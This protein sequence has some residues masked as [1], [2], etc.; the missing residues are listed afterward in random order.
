MVF[1]FDIEGA[2]KNTVDWTKGAVSGGWITG[3][4]QAPANQTQTINTTPTVTPTPTQLGSKTDAM[5]GNYQKTAVAPQNTIENGLTNFIDTGRGF[6]SDVLNNSRQ[7]TVTPETKVLGSKAEQWMN[8][9]GERIKAPFSSRDQY[10]PQSQPVETQFVKPFM[11][12]IPEN[13]IIRNDA[14][15]RDNMLEQARSTFAKSPLGAALVGTPEEKVKA[16]NWSN[17]FN[18]VLGSTVG[19]VSGTTELKGA[20]VA[21]KIAMEGL[22]SG[23]PS[24]IASRLSVEQMATKIPTQIDDIGNMG[25]RLFTKNE[26]FSP[27]RTGIGLGEEIFTKPKIS[28]IEKEY[29]PRYAEKYNEEGQ[30]VVDRVRKG[31][32]I[33][34]EG[35]GAPSSNYNPAGRTQ[36]LSSSKVP[37]LFK[38][39]GSELFN[40]VGK[41]GRPELKSK[42][43][44]TKNKYSSG[45]MGA[46]EQASP[47]KQSA[48]KP[49]KQVH[50]SVVSAIY[51]S[52]KPKPKNTIKQKKDKNTSWMDVAFRK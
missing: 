1:G 36:S 21:S 14:L 35:I 10:I 32:N 2:L 18:S 30:K 5:W 7:T 11:S 46:F 9:G 28:M 48:N 44:K 33:N 19:M 49:T 17:K 13:R 15:Q 51:A 39:T 16:T 3:Q 40:T 45:F 22:E 4:P 52:D 24:K 47:K 50:T 42:P 38:Q 25:S 43:V 29:N 37:D 31:L 34:I 27:V 41:F 20:G 8:T 26:A 23:L 12:T 6:I